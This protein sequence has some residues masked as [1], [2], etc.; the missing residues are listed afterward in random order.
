MTQ[1]LAAALLALG[2]CGSH[3]DQQQQP[4]ATSAAAPR[5]TLTQRQRDSAIGA[6]ALPG[7]RGVSAALGAAATLDARTARADSVGASAP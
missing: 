4:P 3:P 6:S 7:A 2:A 5:A 1:Q